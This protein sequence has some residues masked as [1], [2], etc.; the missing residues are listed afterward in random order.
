MTM[1]FLSA[2][3][4]AASLSPAMQGH[5]RAWAWPFLLAVAIHGVRY[6]V[7]AA[8]FFGLA[9]STKLGRAHRTAPTQ[10]DW[11]LHLRREWRYSALTVLVF[12][13]VNAAIFGLGLN[14]AMRVYFHFGD[15][16]LW[17]FWLSIPAMLLLHDSF[18]YWLH[19]AMHHPWLFARVHRVH[20]LSVFP[21]AFAAYSFHPWEAL[22]EA[23]IVTAILY[24]IPVHPLALLVFQGLSTAY[25][26]YGHC[27]REYYPPGFSAHW[28]GRWINTSTL[29]AHHHL[30]GQKNYGLYF[31]FWDRWMGSLQADAA[32]PLPAR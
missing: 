11:A 32:A 24:I 3:A 4:V 29:H 2:D 28:L 6:V 18:F 19:R 30:R 12:G 27:G 21:T 15:F 7:V 17:W 5:L 10:F 23:L 13:A 31:T 8:V 1:A 20:H 16:P 22:G 9:R 14:A 25:N 26:A